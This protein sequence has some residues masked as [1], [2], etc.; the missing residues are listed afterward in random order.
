MNSRILV[1]GI[2]GPIG[3]ALLPSLKGSGWTVFRLV[4]GP[5]ETP[6]QISWDPAKLIRPEVVSGFDAVIH[7]AGESIF[8]RWTAA[9]KAKIRNSRVL[10]TQHLAQ[11][12]ADTNEKPQV[13]LCGSAIGYYGDRADEE[14]TE[15]S[16]PGA[17]FLAE[18]CQQW[19]EATTPAVQADIR[20]VHLRTGVVL[21]RK[22]GALGAM[23]L[24]FKLGLGGRTGNGQQWMSW[25]DIRD[26]VGGIHHVLKSELLQGPVNMVAPKPVRNAEFAAT[27]AGV[28]SRPAIFPMPAF[29]VKTLFGEMGEELLLSGQKVEPGKLIASGYPFRYSEVRGSLESL[30]RK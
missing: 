29:A 9:K 26:M 20:T 10:G 28:L 23:L 2:S 6:H 15:E 8:G 5:A 19:E 1:S 21:S 11:A 16:A 14:V 30:L 12:L 7:L 13:F 4:R 25:I 22:G 3:S 24:P 17:G 27:L 18:V